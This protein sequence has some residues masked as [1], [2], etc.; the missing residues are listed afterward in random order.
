[1]GTIDPRYTASQILHAIHH[2]QLY[3]FLGAAFVTVGIVA[4][5]FSLL[6][7]RLDPLLLWLALFAI[8]YGNRLWIQTGLMS[9]MIPPSTFFRDLVVTVNYAV[10]IPAAFFFEAAGF[11]GRWGKLFAYALTAIFLGLFIATFAFGALHV[12]DQVN[13]VVVIG[14]FV[15]LIAWSLMRRAATRDFAVIRGGLLVFA[16]FVLYDNII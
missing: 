5:A 12:F 16:A 13:H 2:D 14:A 15:A 10:P 1:M 6:R 8:L 3:L 9:L 11:L 7:R 4:A